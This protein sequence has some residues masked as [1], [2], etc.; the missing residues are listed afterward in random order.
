MSWDW[1]DSWLAHYGDVVAHRFVVAERDG[2]PQGIALLSTGARS[3]L[4]PRTLHLGTAGE[5]QGTS[6]FVEGNGLVALPEE[7]DAFAAL[8]ADT[9]DQDPSWDRLML[10][11]VPPDDAEALLK[12]WPQA[13]LHAD[14]CPVTDLTGEGDVLD[15][16]SGSRRR[17]LRATLRAFGPLELEWAADAA[18]AAAILDELI[19]MHQR[20]WHARGEPGAFTSPRFAAFHREAVGRL[21]PEGGA[22]VVR[23]RRGDE[24]VGCLYGL[25]SGTRLLFYQGGLRSYDDN[26]LR[27]GQ[28]AHLL[29]MRAC[30]ERG[31]TEYDFLAPASR[32]KLELATD[33]KTLVWAE[34]DR[35]RWRTR[36]SQAGRRL[37]RRG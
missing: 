1:T 10:D 32:Y 37:R 30:R 3:A 28:A 29:F 7:R 31:L 9:I 15:A 35:A 4:R 26:R 27:A 36:A 20:H 16:L 22:A 17:R 14:H 5:P 2:E 33:T 6:V 25:I 12:R 23:I 13:R 24:T 19:V 34:V 18:Q 8:L 21:V 11:G